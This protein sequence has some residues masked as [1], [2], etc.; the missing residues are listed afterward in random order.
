MSLTL[1]RETKSLLWTLAILCSLYLTVVGYIS[2]RSDRLSMLWE[3]SF[4]PLLLAAPTIISWL[5]T[6]GGYFKKAGYALTLALGLGLGY[7]ALSGVER[8][9]WVNGDTY[10]QWLSRSLPT[11]AQ[12]VQDLSLLCEGP[13]EIYEKHNGV[14]VR[15]GWI[16]L[17]RSVWQ[18]DTGLWTS[19][20][21]TFS[22]D[23][24]EQN[25]EP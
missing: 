15:C 8:F 12:S 22:K 9:W 16:G 19:M 23:M 4:Y 20:S 14:F 11:D 5:T 13:L 17:E 1:R 25:V 2:V 18:I 10:P 3:L 21:E 24:R 6:S 7:I